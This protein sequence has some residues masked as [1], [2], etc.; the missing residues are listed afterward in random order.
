[1]SVVEG[2][3]EKAVDVFSPGENCAGVN[4]VARSCAD[5]GKVETPTENAPLEVAQL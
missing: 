4:A 2:V 5:I 3:C 1:M